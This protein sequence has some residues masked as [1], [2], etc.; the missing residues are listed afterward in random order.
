VLPD[1]PGDSGDWEAT[2]IYVTI[3][4]ADD[5]RDL[6]ETAAEAPRGRKALN[7]AEWLDDE[8]RIHGETGWEA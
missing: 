2:G 6:L 8:R 5:L 1:D 3:D 4:S 7:D